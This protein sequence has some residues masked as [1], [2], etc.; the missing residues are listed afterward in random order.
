[1]TRTIELAEKLDLSF[2]AG[3]LAGI[4]EADGQ[5]ICIDG[6]R[7]RGIG[8]MCAQVLC[9]AALQWRKSGMRFEIEVS[10]PVRADLERMGLGL[11]L[12]E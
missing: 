10:E 4:S 9:A 3:L 11:I 7:A 2:A 6:R 8:A 1:M 5:H 12:S